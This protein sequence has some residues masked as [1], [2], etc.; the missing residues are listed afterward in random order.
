MNIIVKLSPEVVKG[1]KQYHKL[2]ED[3]E[4]TS[5][6][7]QLYINGIVDGVLHSPREAVSDYINKFER[8]N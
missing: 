4:M 8:N 2:S 7:I 6:D 1:I 3:I 5:K